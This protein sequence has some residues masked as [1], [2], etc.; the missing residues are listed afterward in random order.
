MS[1]LMGLAFSIFYVF[2]AVPL[3]RLA[4]QSVRRCNRWRH[5]MDAMTATCGLAGTYLHLFLARMG[6]GR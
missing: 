5:I 4:D 6:V 1:L 3:G 2:M